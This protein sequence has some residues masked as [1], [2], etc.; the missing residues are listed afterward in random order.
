MQ[1]RVTFPS[2]DLT[3]AGVVHVPEDLADGERRPAIVVLHGFGGSKDGPTH[4]GEASLYES[5]GYIALRFDMRSCGESGGVRGHILCHD[6]VADTQSAITWLAAQ[7]YVQADAIAVSGQ[8]FGGAVALYTGGIDERVG[9]VISVG[10]WGN[11]ARKLQGQHPGPGEWERFLDLLERGKQLRAETGETLMV[12]RW[13]IVPV[14]EHLRRLLPPDRIMDF[15]VDTAQSIYDFVPDE[16]VGNIA[17]RP[18]L[19]YHGA[20][21]SVTPT[22]E[23]L[24]IFRHAKGEPELAI[25]KGDHFPFAEPDPV[26]FELMRTWLGRNLPVGRATGRSPHRTRR[27]VTG[28]DGAGRSVFREDGPAPHYFRSEHSPV[29]AQVLW[30][31]DRMPVD[32]VDDADPAPANRFF[33][34]APPA[35]GTI[36][37]I[38]TFPPDTEYDAEAMHKFLDEIVGDQPHEASAGRH[39]FFHRTQTLDYAIVL[40]G[41]IV[42][43]VDED[44]KVMRPGDV[45]IQRATNHSWS[46]RTDRDC[47]MAFVL[48]DAAG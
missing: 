38:V 30:A 29:A 22:S 2:A 25:L 34:A 27:I 39:F 43:L 46:N 6:Q 9:A 16:V 7:P 24:E 19:I 12:K 20:N 10:G 18:L 44:E 11:G 14:P 33:P 28:H 15:P 36:L 35:N 1:H 4:I 37:R 41:E 21:D 26:L 32:A 5:F 45:L 40:D 13:D 17:P 48:I 8:S 42:A 23:A 3:L 31:T 47:R